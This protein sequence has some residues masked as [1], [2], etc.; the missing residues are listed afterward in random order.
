MQVN[1]IVIRK[2]QCIARGSNYLILRIA[3]KQVGEQDMEITPNSSASDVFLVNQVPK[4]DRNK[5]QTELDLALKTTG[6]SSGAARWL[7][8]A[9]SS[10]PS[11]QQYLVLEE[12]GLR[13]VHCYLIALDEYPL[14]VL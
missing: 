3:E 8:P 6:G 12:E 2:I 14:N 13:N 10:K 9:R 4:E 11:G 5:R 7:V 1:E